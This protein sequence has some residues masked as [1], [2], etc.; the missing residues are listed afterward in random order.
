MVEKHI[1]SPRTEVTGRYGKRESSKTNKWE[2]SLVFTGIIISPRGKLALIKEK[3]RSKEKSQLYK[4]GEEVNGMIIK[5]I[6]PNYIILSGEGK[7]VRLSLYKAE[8]KRPR[9]PSD[10]RI[11][12]G[13]SRRRST[14][15]RG[16]PPSARQKKR[17]NKPI[18]RKG[19]VIRNGK[20]GSHPV[21]N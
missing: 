12:E 6:G 11:S 8:K 9:P 19:T 5:E 4:E 15:K 2:R 7:D 1:F 3:D 16:I 13:S 18:L 17:V 14:L 20:K 10:R 21:G